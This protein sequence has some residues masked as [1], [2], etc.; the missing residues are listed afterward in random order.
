[1]NVPLPAWPVLTTGADF[2]GRPLT[3]QSA[4]QIFKV[5]I[6]LYKFK[7]HNSL[8]LSCGASRFRHRRLTGAP[9]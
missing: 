5:L 6:L 4:W 3:L 8:T 2:N 7:N 9:P 1:M